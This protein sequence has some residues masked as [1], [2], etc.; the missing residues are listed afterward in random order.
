MA[1]D[2]LYYENDYC[3][4]G[5]HYMFQFKICY[6]H[7]PNYFVKKTYTRTGLSAGQ[8]L[9]KI[10]VLI[11]LKVRL[12]NGPYNERLQRSLSRYSPTYKMWKPVCF[13]HPHL[14]QYFQESVG[15]GLDKD[16]IPTTTHAPPC[17][18]DT[19]RNNIISIY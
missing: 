11:R 9:H 10:K 17:G 13:F 12:V 15:T 2:E 1:S 6:K 8:E 5:R 18:A 16:L 19:V 14:C 3:K 7:T 4:K